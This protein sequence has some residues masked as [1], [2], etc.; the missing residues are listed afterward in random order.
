MTELHINGRAVSVPEGTSILDAAR[1]AGIEIPTLCHDERLHPA[2]VCRLCLVEVNGNPHPVAACATPVAAGQKVETYTESLETGRRATLELLVLN[3]PAEEISRWPE[4][5]F[6]HWLRSYGVTGEAVPREMSPP[7]FQDASHPYF[8]ADLTRCIDCFRCVR[9]C[10]EVQ[11][12]FVWNELGRG[13]DTRIVPDGPTLLDSSCVSCG[14]CSDTCPTGALEDHGV[15]RHGAPDHWTRTTC[16]Y[17]GVG[18]EMFAGSRD[19]RLV[20]MKP[21]PDAP[22]NRGHLCV[23]GRYAFEFNHS[24]DR[25][26]EPLL[27]E[28]DGWRA[29]SWP[30]AIDLMAS[31]LTGIRQ[32]H[33][34]DSIG[35]LGSARGTN[36]EN[37][38]AQKFARVVLGTNN[39]DGCARVC[40][41][42]TATGMKWMLGTGAATNSFADIEHAASFLVFGCNP[43][44]NH[45]IV[46]ARIKQAVL[47]G[48]G[49]VVV[50]PR[51]TGLAEM[52]DVHLA[53]RPGTN[54][55]LLNAIAHVVVTEGWQDD[56]AVRERIDGWDEFRAF[57]A[58]WTPE[59]AAA[60]C[61]V[62][63]ASIRAA[64]EIYARRKPAMCFHGLGV[65]EHSQGTESVMALVSLALLTGN[66]GRPGSGINPLRG[67]NNVQGSAHMGCEPG[68][69]TGF[70]SLEKGRLDFSSRWNSPLPSGRG[71]NLM[72]MV[73]AAAA[74]KLKALWA[75]GYDIL[76]TN[77]NT[78]ATRAAL[79][80]LDFVVVQDLFM[81]ELAR[82]VAHLVL[83]AS[84]SFEKDGTFMNGERRVQRVRRAVPAPGTAK[85]D[86]EILCEVARAMGHGDQ[87]AYQSAGEIWDEIRSVW[88]AGAGISYARLEQDGLQWPCPDEAHPGTTILHAET[89]P[90][91]RRATLRTIDFEPTVETVTP[92]FPL[93]LTTGRTLYQFNAGTMTRRT[94]NQQLQ[95]QDY[96]DI[97][98]AD[99]SRLGLRDGD[100]VRV[101]SRHGEGRLPLR[102][103][104]ALSPGQLFATFHT[105]AAGL[106]EVTSPH[107][108]HHEGT[109][110]YKVVAVRLE[111]F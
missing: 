84:S 32:R 65:T 41:Q 13:A 96:L 90:S 73:D 54:V 21:V 34:A 56:D 78:R 47:R 103:S 105:V 14:A 100:R 70:V 38:L 30:E 93:L 94:A 50:D 66:F 12:Q 62:S 28:G 29:I 24:A 85:A 1:A 111:K 91:G 52:A 7:A 36:E 43:T 77:P 95:P 68:H 18:C 4:K 31:R 8:A 61:G 88:P 48:A 109:P 89:F 101:V 25:L 46:G 22:V 72:E 45:P 80:S 108:D 27:R 10:A 15:L 74:G 63:A 37:Y 11:G 99:A 97:A 83:P 6:H 81:N 3:Y 110:E 16:P 55:P 106:N 53:L 104:V 92:D 5:P 71:L 86:W 9:I 60:I 33:G 59:R 82:E 49:L 67:Q 39:V 64:A 57:I 44:E 23:K 75:I 107:R 69:L 20:Q 79:E 2:A 98:P 42:P 26:T 35:V 76:H 87:F 19:G 51:R 102:V 17:C 58:E 40:H